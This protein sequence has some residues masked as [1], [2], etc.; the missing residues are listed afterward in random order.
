[1]INFLI[2]SFLINL[3]KDET[4]NAGRINIFMEPKISAKINV[5]IKVYLLN[6][7]VF[8]IWSLH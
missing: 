7:F 5:M 2:H 6:Y 4:L 8:G 1:M 3:N